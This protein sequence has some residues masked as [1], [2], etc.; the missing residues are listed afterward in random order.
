MASQDGDVKEYEDVF[1]PAEE[2]EEVKGCEDAHVPAGEAEDEGEE[3][4]VD[5]R[6]PPQP[7]SGPVEQ[8]RDNNIVENGTADKDLH[9][10][11]AEGLSFRAPVS[12]H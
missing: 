4:D 1:V 8:T 2:D 6:T 7:T 5:L 11:G 12:V 3:M 9:H 10:L